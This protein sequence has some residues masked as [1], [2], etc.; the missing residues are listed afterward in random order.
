[1]LKKAWGEMTEQTIRNCFR[2]SGI[3]LEAQEGAIDDHDDLFKGMVD[4]GEEDSAVYQLE[5]DLNQLREARPD[6]APEILDA[7]GFVNFDRELAT[8][9]SRPLSVDEIVNEQ[10]PQPV[11]TVED[12]NSNK[13][14]VPDEPISPPSQNE[15]EEAIEI[16]KR[17]RLFTKDLD[18][19]PLLLNV[20]NK[21]NQRR[22]D[23]FKQSS[24]SDFFK[25]QYLEYSDFRISVNFNKIVIEKDINLSDKKNLHILL[26]LSLYN[27]LHREET[28]PAYLFQNLAEIT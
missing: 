28:T 17:L 4:H 23:S 14:Q 20:S 26:F 15:A 8:N 21:I 24:I 27:T 19:D 10:F 3:S 6:L 18:L 25:K 16:M 11:E 22:L 13:D 7:I 9:K 5:F 1:M 2:K 12:G